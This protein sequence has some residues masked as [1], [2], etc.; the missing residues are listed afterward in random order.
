MRR[1]ET[2]LLLFA[3]MAWAA[4]GVGNEDAIVPEDARSVQALTDNA[5]DRVDVGRV[6]C[7]ISRACPR[8]RGAQI[9]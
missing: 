2:F 3:T 1:V 9:C 7:H 4:E 8:S 6:S 5:E